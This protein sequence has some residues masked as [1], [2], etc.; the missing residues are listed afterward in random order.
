MGDW[1]NKLWYSQAM[2]YYAAITANFWYKQPLAW[3]F[4]ELCWVKKLIHK[5]TPFIEHFEM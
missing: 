1:W 3:V 5:V 2:E 4:R